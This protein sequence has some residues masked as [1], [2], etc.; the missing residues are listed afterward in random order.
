M[1]VGARSVPRA[2]TPWQNEQACVK[3]GGWGGG[4]ASV[5]AS[6]PLQRLAPMTPRRQEMRVGRKIFMRMGWMLCDTYA[7]RARP[8]QVAMGS[9]AGRGRAE[10]TETAGRGHARLQ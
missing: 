5:S 4:L 9:A 10:E 6:D 2:S 7:R 1:R 8:G 3:S